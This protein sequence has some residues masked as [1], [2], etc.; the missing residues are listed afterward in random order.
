MSHTL[1]LAGDNT[2]SV[3][4]DGVIPLI[5]ELKVN[6]VMSLGEGMVRLLL[7]R[8]GLKTRIEPIS[9]TEEQ[10]MAQSIASQVQQAMGT[11]FPGAV[12]VGGAPSGPQWDA[13]I[14]MQIT[15]EEYQQL[16]RPGINDTIR[17]EIDKAAQ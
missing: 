10:R 16:G 5:L 8:R 17:M 9:Q 2:G 1:I 11:A 3:T 13:K 15:D 12:I 6:Q 4:S 7:V 14:D